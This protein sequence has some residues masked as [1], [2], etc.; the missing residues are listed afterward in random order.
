MRPVEG[1]ILTVA[2]GA[3][4][5]ARAAAEAG[6]SLVDVAEASR[7]GG[8]RGAGPHAL[9]AAR[10][11]AGRRG[12]RRGHRLPALVRRP[13][14]GARRRA[15]ALAA[16][17]PD[18]AVRPGQ[19][20]AAR[21]P[22]A[23]RRVDADA[24]LAGLRYEVMYLLEAPD[25]TIP[26]FKEVW[27]GLG[28]LHRGGRRRRPVE[29]PHPHRRHRRGHRG[30]A[31]RRPAPHH[32]GDRPPRAGRRGALGPRGGGHGGQRPVGD[33]AGPRPDH[34]GGGR[35]HRRRH[36]AD[37]PVPRRPG[38]HRRRPVDEPVDRRAGRGGRGRAARTR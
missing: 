37:L 15:D 6:K 12:R 21:R 26:S 1:T 35:G 27:A 38:P 22:T 10:A 13:A 2:R 25:E 20:G 30:V 16:R 8:G 17:A 31:R 36:R 3:A 28:R 5:E 23:P 14:L 11:G 19:P 34:R 7:T 24:E 32:P 33:T 9:A 29:L 4:D 18:A